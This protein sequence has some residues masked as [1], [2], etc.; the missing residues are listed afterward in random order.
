MVID[1]NKLSEGVDY[2]LIP[3]TAENEQAW[4][5]RLL[6][7]PYVETVVSFGNLKVNGKEEQIHFNFTIIETPIDGLSPDDVDFQNYVGSVLH[8]VLDNAIAKKEVVMTDVELEK[9]TH[10]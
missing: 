4:W 3:S 6:S 1:I 8:D 7:G 5:V 2:Q 9:T 10:P